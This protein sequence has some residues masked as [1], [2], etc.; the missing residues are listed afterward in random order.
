V[1]VKNIPL[2]M[3]SVRQ[4]KPDKKF[5]AP[6]QVPL[7]DA[8]GSD[9]KWALVR[10]SMKAI[11]DDAVVQSAELRVY[12]GKAFVGS[13]TVSAGANPDGNWGSGVRWSNRPTPTGT[14]L[15]SA[16]VVNPAA[17]A[18]FSISGASLTAWV[19]TRVTT[20]LALKVNQNADFFLSG[21]SAADLRPV[22]VVTY[23]VVPDPP[24]SLRPSGGAVSVPKPDL[25]F[26]GPDDM[27]AFQVQFSTDGGSSVAFDTGSTAAT[28]GYYV[29]AAGSPTPVS[30]VTTLSWRARVTN[31]SGTSAYS[32]WAS[33]TYRPLPVVTITNP[34]DGSN[35][36]DGTPPLTWTVTGP[37]S[38]TGWKAEIN[39]ASDRVI[40]DS[41]GWQDEPATRAWTPSR[42]VKVPGGSGS[43]RLYVRDDSV[44][45]A[46]GANA[47]THVVLKTS[48]QTVESSAVSG[49]SGLAVN[50]VNGVVTITGTRGAGT[51]DTVS[52]LRDGVKVPLWDLENDPVLKGAEGTKFFVGGAFTIPDYTAD[53]RRQHTWKVV[54]YVGGNPAGAG[55]VTARPFDGGCYLLNP[56]DGTKVEV[57]GL[58]DAP[59]NEEVVA[60]NSVLHVPV[61]NGLVVEPVRRRLTRTTKAGTVTGVALDAEADRLQGWVEGA[62]QD[63]YRLVFGINNYSVILGDYSPQDSFYSEQLSQERTQFTL[64]WWER[65]D[66]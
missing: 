55:T 34:V 66:P 47:P 23:V 35:Q 63:R 17:G 29:Q 7:N 25:T 37:V 58:G 54:T 22:L 14:T 4:P 26:D 46:G 10:G 41:N 48:W 19:A 8:T 39:N 3:Y 12:A 43:N 44:T 5:G 18:L 21:S 32:D 16:T 27:S 2:T 24:G 50:V 6:A 9:E 52:L 36:V 64:N 61:T 38:Q 51:P 30:G 40:D 28:Q 53:L 20:G 59:S 33:Y 65:L 31:P 57:W 11:P 45:R 62:Q 60:E 15:A 49:I 13:V 56:R 42:G 1:T